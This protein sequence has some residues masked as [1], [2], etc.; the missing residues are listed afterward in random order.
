[1]ATASRKPPNIK[2][3]SARHLLACWTQQRRFRQRQLNLQISRNAAGHHELLRKLS[4][5]VSD[6]S[7][8]LGILSKVGFGPKK[9]AGK[10]QQAAFGVP[11]S[12]SENFPR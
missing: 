3:A 5:T 7:T 1:M 4:R 10:T 8:L 2:A 11:K 6:R 12:L 9:A